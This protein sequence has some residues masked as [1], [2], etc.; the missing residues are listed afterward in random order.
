MIRRRRRPARVADP[1]RI[2]ELEYELGFMEE[3]ER[4]LF[5]YKRDQE[6]RRFSAPSDAP[7]AVYMYRGGA[8]SVSA[9]ASTMK[10]AWRKP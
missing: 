2:A 6:L 9:L 8:Q 3:H 5:D 7:G 4:A 1:L 10:E